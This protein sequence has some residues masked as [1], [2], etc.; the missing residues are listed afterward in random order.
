MSV[1]IYRDCPPP[2]HLQLKLWGFEVVSLSN[3]PGVPRVVDVGEFIKGKFAIVVGVGELARKFR[4]ANA[5]EREI[6]K[7]LKWLIREYPPPVYVPYLN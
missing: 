5:S 7:F 3:C 6:E 1:V 4:L 2:H